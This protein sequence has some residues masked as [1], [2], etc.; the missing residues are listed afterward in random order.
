M[1]GNTIDCP[2]CGGTVSQRAVA[3]PHCGA[4]MGSTVMQELRKPPPA[5]SFPGLVWV[6]LALILFCGFPYFTCRELIK[7]AHGEMEAR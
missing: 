2:D 6:L 5:R 3:C 1:S 4:P 7:P